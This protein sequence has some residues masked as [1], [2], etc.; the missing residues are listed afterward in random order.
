M[1]EPDIDCDDV[2]SHGHSI[3]VDDSSI[4][5]TDTRN[6]GVSHGPSLPINSSVGTNI[7][8]IFI[9]NSR[10]IELSGS[11]HDSHLLSDGDHY[12]FDK[13][14]ARQRLAHIRRILSTMESQWGTVDRWGSGFMI[15]WNAIKSRGVEDIQEWFDLMMKR[16]HLGHQV[17][18]CLG[19][20]ME[21]E[22]PADVEEWRDLWVQA[23]QLTSTFNVG[24]LSLQYRLDLAAAQQ[25]K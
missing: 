2:I 23:H 7:P 22:M 15:D 12:N 8:Y 19:R 13:E 20:V 24:F 17:Q 9:T 21:G 14:T 5:I 16:I 11:L 1:F 10:T 4:I 6:D 25:L 18:G 3:A